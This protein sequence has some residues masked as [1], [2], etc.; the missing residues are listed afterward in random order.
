MSFS[1]QKTKI[2]NPLADLDSPSL[3]GGAELGFGGRRACVCVLFLLDPGLEKCMMCS[4]EEESP[5][6]LLEACGAQDR[7]HPIVKER[8]GRRNKFKGKQTS[9]APALPDLFLS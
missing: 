2:K 3:G 5:R 7:L 4:H 6:A 8:A 1:G 9:P